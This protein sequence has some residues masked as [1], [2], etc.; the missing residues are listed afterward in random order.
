MSVYQR[1]VVSTIVWLGVILGLCTLM[2]CANTQARVGVAHD[3]T[4]G[5]G[6]VQGGNPVAVIEVTKNWCSN[7]STSWLHISHYRNGWPF[8]DNY[9]QTM[10]MATVNYVFPLTGESLWTCN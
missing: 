1:A 10:D 7:V 5:P 9:E 8:N 4:E 6:H 3:F 2:G